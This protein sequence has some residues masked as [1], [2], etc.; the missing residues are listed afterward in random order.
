MIN[1]APE[2]AVSNPV[3]ETTLEDAIENLRTVIDNGAFYV[4]QFQAEPNSLRDDVSLPDH[5]DFKGDKTVCEPEVPYN[6]M[7]MPLFPPNFQMKIEGKVQEGTKFK[8]EAEEYFDGRNR[9]AAIKYTEEGVTQRVIIDMKYKYLYRIQGSICSIV[10]YD[11]PD[12]VAG[13]FPLSSLNQLRQ[14]NEIYFGEQTIRGIPVNHWQSCIYWPKLSAT[15]TVDWYFAK[16]EYLSASTWTQALVR[17]RVR[18]K[19]INLDEPSG[20]TRDFEHIYD[21]FAFRSD[22][23]SDGDS[24]FLIP[25]GTVCT[26]DTFYNSLEVPMV[27]PYFVFK[28]EEIVPNAKYKFD[29]DE[30]YDD[31]YQLIRTDVK[32]TLKYNGYDGP[33]PTSYIDDYNTGVS[34]IIDLY[35]GNCTI[36]M[37][38]GNSPSPMMRTGSA[39]FFRKEN[40]TFTYR[41]QYPH[42]EIMA[43]V[44]STQVTYNE[45]TTKESSWIVEVYYTPE[46]LQL[47]HIDGS[48][49]AQQIPIHVEA[50]NQNVKDEQLLLINAYDFR[51]NH[52]RSGAF[53]VS[54]CY[55]KSN[56]KRF[57][58]TMASNYW[59]TIQTYEEWFKSAALV[60]IA[61]HSGIS[62]VR[63]HAVTMNLS[64]SPNKVILFF[65]MLVKS[66]LV[67]E[68]SIDEAINSMGTFV[69]SGS[70]VIRMSI[71]GDTTQVKG[72]E[73]KGESVYLFL[74]DPNSLQSFSVQSE[75]AADGYSVGAVVGV[76]IGTF[77]FSISLTVIIML[78][79]S[80][81]KGDKRTPG[82]LP[83]QEVTAD[84]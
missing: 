51:T 17:T 81:K 20:P 61:K 11:S 3:S 63:I 57:Q 77:L 23:Y 2:G 1:R 53:D 8:F 54:Q 5:I 18:G 83:A 75:T 14:G 28:G 71:N 7:P 49:S 60:T 45:G 65:T 37:I 64:E 26:G 52:P 76:A 42:R 41:G 80:K 47:V 25:P 15:F 74:V 67:E 55:H 66:N 34:H 56:N 39:I 70:F 33:V 36:Q 27:P 22:I 68:L 79:V 84:Y 16:P 44:W 9:T 21:Y 4:L 30:Y 35:H 19:A 10:N 6:S 31:E 48:V 38:S 59:A 46:S 58:V 78:Y 32:S 24:P 29:F 13:I 72:M 62:P 12:K 40:L 43:N 69:D 82:G 50:R 73:D